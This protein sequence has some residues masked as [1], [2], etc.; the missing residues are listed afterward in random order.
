MATRALQI[1]NAVLSALRAAP[2]GGVAASSVY[3]DLRQAI[4]FG[5]RPA[6]V[7]DMGD[8]DAPER[9]YNQRERALSLTLRILADGAD[10][11]AV[12]DPIREAAHAVVMLDK[13]QGGLANNTEE[14]GS[15]RDRV[16][17]DVPIASLLT[18][19]QFKYT[20]PGDAL[21]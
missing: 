12:I 21:A 10:P 1:R 18:V 6:I 7:I 14:G 13:T 11:Y 3:A 8:E 20:T 16:D 2:V 17:L 15:S 19:Y 4:S 5:Q 9:K